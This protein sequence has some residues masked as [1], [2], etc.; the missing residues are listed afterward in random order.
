MHAV[1]TPVYTIQIVF[2][3]FP[4]EEA[5]NLNFCNN[6]SHLCSFHPLLM[7]PHAAE[8]L[9]LNIQDIF[10]DISFGILLSYLLH[11]LISLASL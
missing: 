10:N 1:K 11:L 8:C 3:S 2:P 4:K 5:H 7:Y 9:F 6:H